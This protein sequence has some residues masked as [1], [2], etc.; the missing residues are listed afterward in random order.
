MIR[1]QNQS[2]L[3]KIK[4]RFNRK[5][6]RTTAITNEDDKSNKKLRRN[7]IDVVQK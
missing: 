1:N 2:L 4:N 5:L 7:K 6:G 3:S